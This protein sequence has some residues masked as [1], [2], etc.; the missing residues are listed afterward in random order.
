MSSHLKDAF[1]QAAN[2]HGI[3]EVIEAAAVMIVNAL[4]QKNL[5]LAAAQ[6]DVDQLAVDMKTN[7]RL[8]HF[9]P[10]GLRRNTIVLAP[11]QFPELYDAEQKR[12]KQ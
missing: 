3:D 2:G 8:H 1:A 11:E 9:D 12:I 6:D 10:S 5:R 4:R 7:L